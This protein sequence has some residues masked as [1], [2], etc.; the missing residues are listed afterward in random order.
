MLP[1]VYAPL[2]TPTNGNDVPDSL[3]FVLDIDWKTG[4]LVQV[5]D[6]I[7]TEALSK[8][9]LRGS[10]ITGTMDEDGIG[11]QYA[12]DFLLFLKQSL[13]LVRFDGKRV[14]EI[15]CGTGYLLHRLKLLGADVLGVEPGV[16][17]QE[18]S[19]RFHIP[20]IRDF[21]PSAKI[22]GK[23]D[24]IIL[25]GVLEHI[26]SLS[27]FLP[28]LPVHLKENGRI[29]VSVPDC[30]PYIEVG[31]ISMLTCEHYNYY[32]ETS[33]R[34]STRM[35][36]KSDI[37]V[38]RSSFGGCLYAITTNPISQPVVS[39]VDCTGYRHL[40]ESAIGRFLDYLKCTLKGESIGIYVPARAINVLSVIREKIDLSKIRFFDDN[41]LLH[42]TYFPG[43]DIPIESRLEL[44]EKP[45]DRVL[46]MSRT[47]G[48]SIAKQL[49]SSF[50]VTTWEDLFGLQSG[51]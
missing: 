46:I 28:H 50:E 24:L 40:A 39:K 41:T 9:Y 16:H 27:S 20:I 44:I 38:R 15:G 4:T 45:P 26:G 35:H 12:E 25:F 19:K 22:D 10:T 34:N 49:R 31:D 42:G 37:N 36:M 23:F 32:T 3:P 51:G 1:F 29:A 14:L 30:S 13:G 18:G 48:D 21:F 6:K 8:A 11:R 2:R 33:L 47:F 17:G 5:P 7:V 43:F